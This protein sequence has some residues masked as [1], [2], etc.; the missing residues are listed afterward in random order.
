VAPKPTPRFN[1]GTTE[2]QGSPRP[3]AVRRSSSLR[4]GPSATVEE[5]E[6]NTNGN[7][8]DMSAKRRSDSDRTVNQVTH[9]HIF[10]TFNSIFTCDC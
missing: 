6:N 4:T 8:T 3:V 10:L 9:F 7:L 2:N 1:E 5:K